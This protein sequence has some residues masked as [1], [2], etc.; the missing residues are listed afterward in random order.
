MMRLLALVS[1]IFSVVC[2]YVEVEDTIGEREAVVWGV[3]KIIYY[4][5]DRKDALILEGG[6]TLWVRSC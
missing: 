3:L 1:L 2:Y 5:Q 6:V 4:E